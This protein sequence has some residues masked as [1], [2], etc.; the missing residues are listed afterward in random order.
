MTKKERTELESIERFADKY[1][2]TTVISED[3]WN[4][5][6]RI[7]VYPCSTIS[8]RLTELLKKK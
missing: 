2:D 7:V 4:E 8:L 3:P 6:K 5:G 1:M